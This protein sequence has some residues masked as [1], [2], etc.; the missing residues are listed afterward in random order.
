MLATALS[1]NSGGHLRIDRCKVVVE[2]PGEVSR[3]PR[4]KGKRQD[5]T[6][7]EAY[8]LG[9]AERDKRQSTIY[10]G[11]VSA[12][13]HNSRRQAISCKRP[14]RGRHFVAAQGIRCL[15]TVPA[16]TSTS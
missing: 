5:R 3:H 1:G 4:S 13:Y 10:R 2:K 8:V 11:P 6:Y 7:F 16:A 12:A 15:R 14:S 9:R